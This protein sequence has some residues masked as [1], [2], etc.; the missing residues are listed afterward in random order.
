MR[1]PKYGPAEYTT[2]G[3]IWFF[4]FWVFVIGVFLAGVVQLIAEVTR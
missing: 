2:I 1:D 3:T 4:A